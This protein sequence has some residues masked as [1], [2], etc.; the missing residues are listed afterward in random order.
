VESGKGTLT[1]VVPAR[2]ASVRHDLT[3]RGWSPTLRCVALGILWKGILLGLGAAAPIGPVNVEIARRSLRGGFRA[4]CALGLGAVTIDVLYALL[5]SFGVR[6]VLDHQWVLTTLTLLGAGLL[7]YL[8]VQCFR[9]ARRQL[10]S[11]RPGFPVDPTLPPSQPMAE[12]PPTR[13]YVT[14]LLMTGLNP[15]TLVFWF[16]VV[17]G[18]V[19]QISP[20]PAR[21]LPFICAGVFIG[22]LSWVL[23]FA[24]IMSAAGRISRHTVLVCADL[25]GGVLLL[26]FALV[27][28]WRV[29]TSLL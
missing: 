17:P 7:A 5:T 2:K 29:R 14:G 21:E 18:M 4:G 15:M 16:V 6:F 25:V 3:R 11:Q 27:A 24:S 23:F 12:P 20:D 28:I 26:A 9:S 8:G 19:G 10:H 22:A 13:N 1:G